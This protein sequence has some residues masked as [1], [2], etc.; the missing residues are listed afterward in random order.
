MH[1][2]DNSAGN[3]GRAGD[4]LGEV[5]LIKIGQGGQGLVAFLRVLRQ[6]VVQFHVWGGGDLG[7][8]REVAQ[9]GDAGHSSRDATVEGGGGQAQ[10]TRLTEAPHADTAGIDLGTAI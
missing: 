4:L 7:R 8:Y 1:L 6:V 5:Q 3:Q 9:P 2:V 10:P